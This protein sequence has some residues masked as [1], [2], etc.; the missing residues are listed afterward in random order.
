M[1]TISYGSQTEFESVA[2]GSLAVIAPM[3]ERMGVRGIIDRHLPVDPQ[4]EFGIGSLLSLLVAARLYSPVALSNVAQWAADSGADILWGIPADKLNDDRL[5][6]ALDRFFAQRHSI[7]SSVA[8]HVSQEFGVPLREVHYDPTH[9]LFTGAYADAAPRR[10]VVVGGADPDE[11][12]VLSDG[13]L[14]AAHITKGRAMDDAPKGSKMIHA[15]LCVQVDEFGPLPIFGHTVDGN[16]NGRHAVHE[17]FELLRKHLPSL[18]LTIISDRGTFSAGHLLRLKDGGCDAICSA[19]WGEFSRLFDEQFPS[20]SWKRATYLSIEQQRR[21]TSPGDLPHEEYQLATVR[22]TLT[23]EKTGRQI[24][25]RVIFAHSTADEKVIRQ[26]RQKQIDR[27]TAELNQIQSGVAAGRQR[28]EEPALSRRVA[29]ALG[30]AAAAKYFSHRIVPLTPAELKRQPP[31]GRGCRVPTHRF[32][33]TFDAEQQQT[34]EEYDGYNAIVTTVPKTSPDELFTRYKQQNY[35]EQVNS[36]FKGPLAVRPVFLH[37]P[38]R[39]ESLV[40]LMM[41]AL[42]LH[43]LIQRTYRKNLPPEATVKQRRT[44]TLT[45]LNAFRNYALLVQTTRRGRIVHTTRL[46]TRQREILQHLGIPSP[47]QLLSRTLPRPPD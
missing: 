9:I 38:Q 7:L 37:S 47:A 19:P 3:L 11:G 42:T 26:Q 30:T 32:E 40:F 45:L 20:L 28:T 24:A 23:D 5:G 8:L 14:A 33:F 16:Q 31:P 39:V 29:R 35:S 21:R 27:I 10:G 43:F 17:Q 1:D 15:G 4:A 41:I 34:D 22:H 25:C 12:T 36:R 2:L 18:A 13:L 46:T 44:T 6:R